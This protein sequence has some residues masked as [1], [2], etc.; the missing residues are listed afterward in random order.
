MRRERPALSSASCASGWSTT[1]SPAP[2]PLPAGERVGE[3]GVEHDEVSS[4]A[5]VAAP[6]QPA[7]EPRGGRAAQGPAL[8]ALGAQP[9]GTRRAP[10][11]PH[12]GRGGRRRR[13]R[14]APLALVWTGA[15]GHVC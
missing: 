5:L 8:D 6:N 2:P 14:A 15:G 9:E 12:R 1:R 13:G 4:T 7:P 11:A 3:R 10:D